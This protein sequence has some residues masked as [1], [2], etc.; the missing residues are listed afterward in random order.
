MQYLKREEIR[1]K[2]KASVFM[3]ELHLQTQ[4]TSTQKHSTYFQNA[5]MRLPRPEM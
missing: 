3:N 2:V 4:Q 1:Q 5:L